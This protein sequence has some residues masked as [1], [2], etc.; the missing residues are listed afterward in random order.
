MF[1]RS[2]LFNLAK[3]IL[4]SNGI[5]MRYYTLTLNLLDILDPKNKEKTVLSFL[6]DFSGKSYLS[7]KSNLLSSYRNLKHYSK[8]SNLGN[9]FGDI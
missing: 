6:K 1:L 5:S 7:F 4:K 9:L 2:S 8:P 3:K